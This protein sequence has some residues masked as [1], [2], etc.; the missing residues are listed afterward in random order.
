M[1]ENTISAYNG[2]R[3]FPIW[4]ILYKNLIYI[5]LAAILGTVGGYLVGR[6]TVKPS[7]TAK[8]S[9]IL[10]TSLDPSSVTV[11]T[12]TTDLSLAQLVLPSVLDF[13][14]APE[15]VE[16]ANDIYDGEGK[17]YASNISTS[18]SENCIF[19]IAYTD[20]DVSVVREKLESVIEGTRSVINKKDAAGINIISAGEV[21]F[22]P[23]QSEST[24]SRSYSISKYWVVGFLAGAILSVVIIVSIYFF[25]NKVKDA[26][27]LEAITGTSVIA[28]V[29]K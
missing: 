17:I 21:D 25:D 18:S 3:E 16:A 20:D 26:E 15:T 4:K 27:T 22:I 9:V 28:Y 23:T 1:E 8:C 13:I 11:S 6:Y 29:F 7:Y 10:T 24:V 5:I 19:L 14:K 12:A 2:E